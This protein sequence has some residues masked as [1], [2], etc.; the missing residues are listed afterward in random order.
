[1]FFQ[2]Y[3]KNN[4]NQTLDAFIKNS[5]VIIKFLHYFSKLG[6]TEG[7]RL[8]VQMKRMIESLQSCQR[9][10]KNITSKMESKNKSSDD[11]QNK[12]LQIFTE[13]RDMQKEANAR[14]EEDRLKANQQREK[15]NKLLGEII[16]LQQLKKQ[17]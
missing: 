7:V 12:L 4:N 10:L 8:E 1:M 5:V 17:S 2:M 14:A 9:V 15:T 3:S 11:M 6:I 13:I 16:K